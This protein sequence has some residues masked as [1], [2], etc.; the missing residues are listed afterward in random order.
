MQDRGRFGFVYDITKLATG[1]DPASLRTSSLYELLT[2]CRFVSM[3]DRLRIAHDMAEAVMQLHT[4]GWL[5]KGVCSEHVRFVASA[6]L[7]VEAVVTNKAYL[8]GY[9]YA[10]PD[11]TVAAAMTE[12]PVTATNR[13]LYRH[14]SARGEARQSF[15]K[16]FD[17]YAL[18]C[19]LIELALWLRLENVFI[20][21]GFSHLLGNEESAVKSPQPSLT[22]LF[23][24]ANF[25]MDLLH[26]VGPEY[27]K[28]VAMCLDLPKSLTDDQEASTMIETNVLN[29]L[30]LC[31]V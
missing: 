29:R 9:G 16:R 26:H 22:E 4:A 15:Q 19:V 2:T 27:T 14:P 21:H 18:A 17:T 20:K 10:R 3:A 8:V 7:D 30:R 31:K 25:R 5:H 6:N 28:A 24:T 12:L 1:S 11:T 23:N 13:D